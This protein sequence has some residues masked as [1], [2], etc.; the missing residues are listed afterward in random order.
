MTLRKLTVLAL[1][2]ALMGAGPALAAYE[3]RGPVDGL[4]YAWDGTAAD[5]FL[6]ET[7]G[8]Y[9]FDYGDEARV[10]F[11]LPFNFPFNG[12]NYSHIVANADGTIE[13]G[14]AGG[15]KVVAWNADLSSYFYG[16]LFVE[17]KTNPERV[18]VEWRTET[19]AG[20]GLAQMNDFEAVLTPFGV[21]RFDYHGFDSAATTD[22]G[23]GLDLN[24]D[25]SVDVA[26]ASVPTLAQQS[27]VALDDPAGDG[28]G[29]HLSN[30]DEYLAATDP[31]LADSDGDGTPDGFDPDPLDPAIGG[32]SLALGASSLGADQLQAVSVVV[33]DLGAPGEA[34]TL[35]QYPDLNDNGAVDPNELP[36]R[37]LTIVD[38]LAASGPGLPGDQ[39]GTNDGQITTVLSFF[40]PLAAYHA[41]GNYVIRASSAQGQALR[42]L[43]IAP[44]LQ[45]QAVT[46]TVTDGSGPVAGALVR[47][48]DKWQRTRAWGLSDALGDYEL[49]VAEP[50]DYTVLAQA[51]G[52]SQALAAAP[53][54]SL[55]AGTS[56]SGVDLALLAGANTLSGAVTRSSDGQGVG[57]IAVVAESG[58][59][60]AATLTAADGSYAFSL[61]AGTYQVTLGSGARGPSVQG[62]L[63]AATAA[64]Q[65]NLSASAANIDFTLAPAAI[66]VT[67]RALD[68]AG[69]GVA[70]LT[71]EARGADG[72]ITTAVTDA[73]GQYALPV[74]G[75]AT[76]TI[77]LAESAQLRGYIAQSFDFDPA[78]TPATGNDLTVTPIAAWVAGT[79]SAPDASPLEAVPVTLDK[80]SGSESVTQNTA[81]DG[82]YHL[83]AY[84]GSWS[85]RAATEEKGYLP[86]AAQNLTLTDGQ[87][88]AVDFAAQANNLPDLVV[89]G[90]TYPGAPDP[91]QT[92]SVS[93]IFKNLGTSF[94]GTVVNN[95]YLSTDTTITTTDTYLGMANL[96]FWNGWPTGTEKTVVASVTLPAGLPAATYYLGVVADSYQSIAE[97][98]ETNNV[99]SGYPIAVGGV[100]PDQ[101]D[102]SMAAITASLTDDQLS[103]A[104]TA[105]NTGSAQA[106]AMRVGVYLSG[107]ATVTTADT[108]VA[109]QSL[110]GLAAGST[111]PISLTATWPVSLGDGSYYVGA[112]VDD[113]NQVAEQNETNNA[114][115]GNQVTFYTP[116]PDLTATSLVG[117]IDGEQITVDATLENAGDAV[118]G[119]FQAGVYLS[120]DASMTSADILVGSQTYAGL[121]AG[122]A[123]SLNQTF[124]LPAGLADGTYN[125]GI[126]VDEQGQVNEGN[127]SNN[128]RQG[129]Q[130]TVGSGLAQ[131]DL[132]VGSVQGPVSAQSGGQISVSATIKNLGTLAAPA[133]YTGI[134]LS[135]DPTIEASDTMIGFIYRLVFKNGVWSIGSLDIGEEDTLVRSLTVPASLQPGNYYLGAIA[136]MSGQVVESNEMNNAATE[137][138]VT[139]AS[140]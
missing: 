69:M 104:G 129:N 19:F 55:S 11:T 81:V 136:D 32:M 25:G 84:A 7:P 23:S 36:F 88:A 20:E 132:V 94:N 109:S 76:S 44:A 8:Q 56:Q 53:D 96:M 105:Q 49:Q 13:L 42:P 122:A 113:Q 135:T 31:T 22:A 99:S 130:V 18:V 101:P 107:D 63:S 133:F 14:G 134:Y 77:T 70:G 59:H 60:R 140:P 12:A 128:I 121:A 2:L 138:Q 71:L 21:I 97:A 74:G 27:F 65:V 16:G 87:T 73:N 33:S 90:L 50:G 10:A 118:A 112:I 124:T 131:A 115:A 82:S 110:A 93:V 64:Q 108:F 85:V 62:Y 30:F 61:P 80:A 51:S 106:G 127:E 9:Q 126:I 57:G 120:L 37:L 119:A 47:L 67:G 5:R 38:G 117:A 75:S 54:I 34:V 103:I 39:D 116:R 86:A 15:P 40:D 3:L 43:T 26:L 102:L 95:I 72:Q 83:G 45:A 125:L 46:G 100:L 29:D 6:P 139:I 68:G 58:T 79:V 35:G 114:L 4:G 91:G 41:P 17:H 137:G 89:S 28:D 123:T 66:I 78:T 111:A 1:V 48:V 52:L 98:N 92:I 24:G